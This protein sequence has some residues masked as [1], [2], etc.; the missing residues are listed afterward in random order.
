LLST[1][2]GGPKGLQWKHKD[3]TEVV[4]TALFDNKP[5]VTKPGVIKLAITATNLPKLIIFKDMQLMPTFLT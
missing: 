5:M 3:I 4:T 2:A 1:L